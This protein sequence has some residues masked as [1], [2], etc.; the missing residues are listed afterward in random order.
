MSAD[1]PALRVDLIEAQSLDTIRGQ[2]AER[3]GGEDEGREL[4]PLHTE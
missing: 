4:H 3:A 1:I 2:S